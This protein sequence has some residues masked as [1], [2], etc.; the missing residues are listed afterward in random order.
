MNAPPLSLPLS[1]TIAFLIVTVLTACDPA[2][3]S[4]V[5]SA[6]PSSSPPI[7]PWFHSPKEPAGIDFQY[8]SGHETD[9]LFP[10]IMGGGVACLDYD[11]DGWWD[12]Y[13]LQG[14]RLKN[15]SA[16][17]PTN[18]LFRNLGDGQFE[19]VTDQAKV[20]HTGYGMGAVCGD[21]D[22][23]GH[24]DI[25]VTNVGANVLYRNLGNGQFEDISTQSGLAHEGW[26]TSASFLDFDRDGDLDLFV[27]NYIHWSLTTETD[28]YS[29]GGKADYCSPLSYR[30]PAMDLLYR[31]DG[32]GRFTD[33]TTTSGIN[34][35]FG[36]GLGVAC[37]D[38]DR[39]GWVDIFVANDASPNQL[40][41]NQGNGTFINDALIRGCA[42]NGMGLNEA[43]MGV[44]LTDINDD[45]WWDLFVT[46]LENESNTFYRNNEG[47]FRDEVSP[48]GPGVVSWPYTGF[49]VV[50]GDFNNDTMID[51]FVANGRV[52]YG[53]KDHHPDDRFAEPNHLLKGLGD[54]KFEDISHTLPNQRSRSAA[55][56]GAIQGDLNNDG[57]LDLVTVNRDQPA[58]L[59]FNRFN[60]APNTNWIRFRIVTS[61]GADAI[62]AE[63][64]VQTP[65]KTV[66]R[67]VQT[68]LGYCSSQDPRIHL[69][70]GSHSSV[71]Q[72]TVT[73]SDNSETTFGPFEANQTHTLIQPSSKPSNSF[74]GN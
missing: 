58:T 24:T 44:A 1:V 64:A 4:S 40:W 67:L 7:V 65:E 19:D 2:P 49:G 38:F 15:E 48:Q 9:F 70:L 74:H 43:G 63:V 6:R 10:E 20:G 5:E 33:V 32:G 21:V 54:G 56:R 12:L 68:G 60:R 18:R 3:Q 47:Y 35:S 41:L 66:L 14:G 36:N 71:D 28:C 31:N 11:N 45:G 30:S 17:N 26:G 23:D 57:A 37:A 59:L 72:V 8:Q 73:W 34:Q 55:S 22:N 42:V 62:G 25:F 13:F 39:N 69:G 61:H 16:A 53:S 27:A 52:K 50:F 46:H 51:T 29:R